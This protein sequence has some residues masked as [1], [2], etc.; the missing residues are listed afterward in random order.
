MKREESSK[1]NLQETSDNIMSPAITTP[2]LTSK[3]KI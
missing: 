2:I 3:N 1:M